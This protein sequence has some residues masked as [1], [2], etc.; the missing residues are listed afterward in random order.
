MWISGA[1]KDFK[2]IVVGE[3]KYFK[4][5]SYCIGFS[6]LNC[7]FYTFLG[8]SQVN[9]NMCYHFLSLSPFSEKNPFP[10]YGLYS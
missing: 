4:N 8:M 7:S 10:S 5:H 1:M 2:S 6:E 9:Q 3:Y